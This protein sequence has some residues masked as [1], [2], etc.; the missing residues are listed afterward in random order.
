[1]ALAVLAEI[2]DEIAARFG[3]DRLAIVHR[4]GDVPL[5]DVVDRGRRRR[6]ASRRGVRGRPLRHR[7]DQGAGPDLEGRAVRRRPRLDRPSR[8]HRTGGGARREGLH[9]RRHGGHRR[10]QPSATRPTPRTA[11]TRRRSRS[12]S[13]RRTRPSRAPWPAGATDVLVNDSH[14]N[15]HNLLPAE[16]HPR[17]SGAPGREGVVDGR[18]RPARSRWRAR[19]R[20]RPVRRLPR[21]GRSPDRDDRP[22]LQ[23]RARSRPGSTAGRPAST[24]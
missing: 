20:R 7:R 4:T 14:W 19:L 3:V 11:A 13:A 5:G 21:P 6:A 24:A 8:S 15:M 1:M 22:H 17:G 23:R 16:L 12:W 9:Q 10:D 2:A 18:R